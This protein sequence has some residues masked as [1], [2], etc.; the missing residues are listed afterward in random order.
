RCRPCSAPP[1]SLIHSNW[2]CQRRK[3]SGKAPVAELHHLT[4]HDPP[5]TGRAWS[6]P[7]RSESATHF[8]LFYPVWLPHQAGELAKTFTISRRHRRSAAGGNCLQ[9]MLTARQR[10]RDT[11]AGEVGFVGGKDHLERRGGRTRAGDG[12]GPRVGGR[13]HLADQLLVGPDVPLVR[14]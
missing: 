3:R 8:S 10:E 4:G 6:A 5:A 7:S 2:R 9:R 1:T 11:S 12:L 14:V 13:E